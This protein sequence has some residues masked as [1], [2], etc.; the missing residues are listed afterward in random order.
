V[1]YKFDNWQNR[2]GT[3]PCTWKSIDYIN[4]GWSQ[5]QG[6][7][8]GFTT[9]SIN[10][11]IYKD[12]I[13]VLIPDRINPVFES[14]LDFFELDEIVCDLS[15]Y[16]PGMILPWHTDNYPTY[17][18]NK[19]VVDGEQIVRIIVLLHDS[20]PGQQLWI[21]DK[22][23]QGSVGSWF[24]WQGNSIHMAAN[25]SETDR[26]VLQITGLIPGKGR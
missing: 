19:K 16:T 18:R 22:I 15:K 24:S 17:S 8:L 7:K 23:C 26:Y 5:H 20:L 6:E 2:T 13:S 14:V 25:L 9:N 4:A 1:K 12:N 11:D 21:K 3:V 10:Y